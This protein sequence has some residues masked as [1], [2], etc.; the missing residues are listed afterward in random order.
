MEIEVS[1]FALN[2]IH[3]GGAG[4]GPPPLGWGQVGAAGS[5][6]ASAAPSAAPP[7]DRGAEVATA[8]VPRLD[9]S[10]AHR[11]PRCTCRS[12]RRRITSSTHF[13]GTHRSPSSSPSL[14]R[15]FNRLASSNRPTARMSEEVPALEAPAAADAAP[16]AEAPAEAPQSVAEARK[17]RGPPLHWNRPKS[18]VYEYN[19]DYG[20]NYYKVRAPV[21]PF[22]FSAPAP[23]DH[24]VDRLG[25]FFSEPSHQISQPK[26][27][28]G[29]RSSQK[30]SHDWIPI[31][32]P[33]PGAQHFHSSSGTA[34]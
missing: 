20:G 23:A 1:C 34:R 15:P 31:Q 17:K 33:Q 28:A 16:P 6:P 7:L 29:Q 32:S 3:I 2:E 25:L 9:Q 19:F 13:E 11:R 24:V 14:A 26:D 30:S 10:L 27:C 8:S 4:R 18:H 12:S 21:F 22:F 5:A